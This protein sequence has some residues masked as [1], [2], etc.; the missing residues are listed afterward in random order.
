[1]R[2]WWLSPDRNDRSMN[3]HLQHISPNQYSACLFKN[4]RFWVNPDPQALSEVQVFPIPGKPTKA[5]KP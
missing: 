4:Q 3:P 1:M 5:Q 2:A